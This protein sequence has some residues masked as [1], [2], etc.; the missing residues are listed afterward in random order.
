[1]SLREITEEDLDS[2]E[3]IDV[4]EFVGMCIEE[5]LTDYDGYGHPVFDN[6]I[7]DL[8]LAPSDLDMIHEDATHILWYKN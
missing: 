2:G 4:D 1:M 8:M 3:L 7:D 6:E 5:E